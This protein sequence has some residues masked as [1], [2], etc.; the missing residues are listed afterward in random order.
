MGR[1]WAFTLLY[2]LICYLSVAC[3]AWAGSRLGRHLRQ[4]ERMRRFNRLLALLL[5]VSAGY[6]LMD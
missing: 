1:I 5:V 4:P 6:L 3:W 2:L